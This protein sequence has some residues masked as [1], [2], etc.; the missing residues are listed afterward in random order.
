[1]ASL[2]NR[3]APGYK[4]HM[5]S[6]SSSPALEL[7]VFGVPVAVVVGRETRLPLKRAIALV[8]Y[9]GFNTGP[10]PRAHLAAML[11]PD[12]DEAQGRTRLRRLVYTIEHAVGG[13]VLS[14]DHDGLAFAA[15]AVEIDAL[16]FAQFARR[17]VATAVFDDDTVTEARQWVE[18]ARRPLMQGIAFGSDTFDDW[19]TATAL[20]HEHLLTRLLERLIDAL[21]G[22]G[23]F[24][25]ALDLAEVL[26]SL[27]VYREPSY[28]LLMH[29]H[30]LQGHSAGVEAAFVRCAEVLRAEFGIKPGP[31]TER[32]YLQMTEDLKR[33]S[34]H[35]LERSSVRFA[36]GGQGAIAYTVLGAGE[37]TLVISPG[38]VCHIEI[39]LEHPTFRAFVEALADRF[40]VILFDRR[41]VGLSERLRATSTPAA[42]AADIAAILDHAGV[43]R[44]WLFGSSEGGMS[45]MRLAVDRPDRVHGLC[46]FGSL[47]RGSAAS[48]YPW[49]LPASAYDEWLRRL[50]A[51]W[52]GPVGIE[53][54]AP[55]Q[56]HDPALRAWWARLL[57]H[58]ASPGGIETILS[59]LR[60]ADLRADLGR[61]GVPT[62]VMHRRGDHAV[63][64]E[65]GEHLARHIPGAVWHPLD[66]VD[67]FWWC[68]DSAPIIEAILKF[69]GDDTRRA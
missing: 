25:S 1:M 16:R 31:I 12:A 11:W 17:A 33:L 44:A 65:A 37:R 57:R 24:A 40:R 34:S 63:R 27:D 13:K 29:L 62:L 64:F 42:T 66:G 55:S 18:R 67:H 41:G 47:A 39:A 26:V 10:V 36:E 23:E 6:R 68:G 22:R 20:E 32:A 14:A 50:I 2:C 59:G 8:A 60:D 7:R 21:G 38:F 46:L 56:Q 69:T 49:A 54:F 9:L 43:S 45:A 61:I 48:D 5:V 52:G 53:T 15:Q 58:G 3:T 19:L 4:R 30:A 35:A 28:V 51:G